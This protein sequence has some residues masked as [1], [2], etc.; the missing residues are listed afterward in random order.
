MNIN[1]MF[2]FEGGNA[3]QNA[4]PIRGDLAAPV[5]YSVI[6]KLKEHFHCEASPLGST[7]KKDKDQYSGDID[8]AITIPWEKKNEVEDFVENNITKNYVELTGLKIVSMGYSYKMP[9]TNEIKIVQV[10]LMFVNDLDYAIF[11]YHSPNFIK[12][13]SK[14]KGAIR[15]LLLS[16]C[17]SATPIDKIL[18]HSNEYKSEYF[19]SEDYNGKY[20]GQVKSFWKFSYNKTDGVSL[21]KKSFVGKLKILKNPKIVERK[22]VYSDIDD[23]IRIFFGKNAR[24]SDFNSYESIMKLLSSDNYKFHNDK[25]ILMNAFDIFMRNDEMNDEQKQNA[26]LDIKDIMDGH[27]FE[28]AH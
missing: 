26:E 6:K 25:Q 17:V 23:I 12:H 19:T 24:R 3:V 16:A 2:L 15:N 10:D 4:E 18:P 14:Y 1:D 9:D 22:V 13:E 28:K 8:I 5:A 20:E 11:A 7:G 27:K 21:V